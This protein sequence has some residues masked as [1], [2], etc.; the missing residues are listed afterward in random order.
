MRPRV[1]QVLAALMCLVQGVRGP[2]MERRSVVIQSLS[3][4]EPPSIRSHRIKRGSELLELL[5]ELKSKLRGE[6]DP[7]DCEEKFSTFAVARVWCKTYVNLSRSF[8]SGSR[9][10]LR[11]DTLLTKSKSRSGQHD[12]THD[13]RSFCC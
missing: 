6:A 10:D 2:G 5:L 4:F 1:T 9:F 13:V 7:K 11:L 8:F 3:S 12:T